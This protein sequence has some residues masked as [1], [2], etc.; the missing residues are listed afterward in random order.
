MRVTNTDELSARNDPGCHPLQNDNWAL[1][2]LRTKAQSLRT[3]GEVL[4]IDEERVKY[5]SR[6]NAFKTREPD[7]PIRE[8]WTIIK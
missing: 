2:H 8:G 6:E 4:C 1:A 3:P 7:K 5:R